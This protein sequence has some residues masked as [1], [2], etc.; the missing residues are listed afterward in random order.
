MGGEGLEAGL[1]IDPWAEV[2]RKVWGRIWY[3]VDG[4]GFYVS[5]ALFFVGANPLLPSS[6][7]LILLQALYS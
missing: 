3:W 1:S 2:L 6:N 7:C 4:D 5:A